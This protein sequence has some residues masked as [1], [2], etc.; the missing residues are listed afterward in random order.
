MMHVRFFRNSAERKRFGSTYLMAMMLSTMASVPYI[1]MKRKRKVIIFMS[2]CDFTPSIGLYLSV[3]ESAVFDI[4]YC[5]LLMMS[6]YGSP[7]F[8]KMLVCIS[9]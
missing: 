9:L 3:T 5:M 2:H 8:L 7:P 6:Q 4:W 1:N